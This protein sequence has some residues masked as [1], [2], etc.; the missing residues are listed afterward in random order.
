MCHREVVWLYL[1]AAISSLI[2]TCQEEQALYSKNEMVPSS[3]ADGSIVSNAPP[4][5][6]PLRRT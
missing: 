3:S 4:W 2:D 6:V 1:K 5:P